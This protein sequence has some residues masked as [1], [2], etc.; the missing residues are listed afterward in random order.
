MTPHTFVNPN[1]PNGA[2]SPN[3][4]NIRPAS[5]PKM[6]KH[7]EGYSHIVFHQ[8]SPVQVLHQQPIIRNPN[9]IVSRVINSNEGIPL[10][11]P[12]PGIPPSAMGQGRQILIQSPQYGENMPISQNPQLIKSQ[13]QSGLRKAP[14]VFEYQNNVQM[15]STSSTN[16]SQQ[17]QSI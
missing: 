16:W 17:S 5:A 4:A 3:L 14:S 2:L 1:Y 6:M 10:N 7:P 11:Y 8:P 9:T 15:N 13:S 12:L